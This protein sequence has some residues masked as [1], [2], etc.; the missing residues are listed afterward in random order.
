MKRG[1]LRGFCWEGGSSI[2]DSAIKIWGELCYIA[3][4]CIVS[5]V[6][7]P[8]VAFYLIV[9]GLTL[10]HKYLNSSHLK[11]I[12]ALLTPYNQLSFI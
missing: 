5:L 4:N 7:L 6:C 11:V 1:A 2:N 10:N 8:H 9:I 3:N 12:P